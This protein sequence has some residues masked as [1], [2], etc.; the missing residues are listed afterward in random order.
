MRIE[1]GKCSYRS[2]SMRFY[3]TAFLLVFSYIIGNAQSTL[4]PAGHALNF[5]TVNDYVVVDNLKSFDFSAN[6]WTIALWV[7]PQPGGDNLQGLVTKRNHSGESGGLYYNDFS[8]L[9]EKNTQ[10]LNFTY[11][12]ITTFKSKTAVFDYE[13]WT[14]IA[15]K[16]SSGKIYFYYD[17]V[18]SDSLTIS[19]SLS[20]RSNI[21][22]YIGSSPITNSA[23]AGSFV[24]SMD[25]VQ[26]WNV[27]LTDAAIE[28]ILH[29]TLS[30]SYVDATIPGAVW[31]NLIA[32]YRFDQGTASGN[33]SAISTIVSEPDLINSVTTYNGTLNGFTRSG[34][35]SNFINSSAPAGVITNQGITY[36]SYNSVAVTGTQTGDWLLGDPIIERGVVYSTNRYFDPFFVSGSSMT[37]V[38]SSTLLSQPEFTV[39]IDDLASGRIYYY[40]SYIRTNSG[41]YAYGNE[42]ILA[43]GLEPTGNALY[44]DGVNDSLGIFLEKVQNLSEWSFSMWIKPESGVSGNNVLL[45]RYFKSGVIYIKTLTLNYDADNNEFDFEYNDGSLQSSTIAANITEGLW[46]HIAFVFDGTDVK[47][48]LNGTLEGTVVSSVAPQSYALERLIVGGE[49]NNTSGLIQNVFEGE[50]DELTFWN[51]DITSDLDNVRFCEPNKERL[52]TA[53]FGVGY[54][55]LYLYLNF[56]QGIA[57]GNNSG[58]GAAPKI[59]RIIDWGPNNFNAFIANFDLGNSSDTVSNFTESGLYNLLTL[60]QILDISLTS[61]VLTGYTSGPWFE[62]GMVTRGVVVS[63]IE[64]FDPRNSDPAD[65]LMFYSSTILTKDTFDVQVTGLDLNTRYF[66]RVFAVTNEGVLTFANQEEL[67]TSI[68][69][70]GYALDFDGANDRVQTPVTRGSLGANYTLSAWFKYEGSPTGG[71]SPIFGAFD[72]TG[73]SDFSLSKNTGNTNFTYRDGTFRTDFGLGTNAWD[74]NWHHVAVVFKTSIAYLYLDGILVAHNQFNGGAGVGELIQVGW[75]QRYNIAFNGKIDEVQIWN[76]ALSASQIKDISARTIDNDYITNTLGLSSASLLAYYRFDAGI[77]EGDNTSISVLQD[78]SST[79]STA[80]LSGFALTGTNSNFVHSEAGMGVQTLELSAPVVGSSTT[81]KG[82]IT[83]IWTLGRPTVGGFCYSTQKS[84]NYQAQPKVAATVNGDTLSATINSLAL[85]ETYFYRAWIKDGNDTVWGGERSFVVVTDVPGNALDLDG[86]NDVVIVPGNGIDI[87]NKSFTLETWAKKSVDSE[88]GYFFGQG[89]TI[90]SQGLH[91]GYRSSTTLTIAFYGNDANFI[92]NPDDLWHHYA[93]VYDAATKTRRFYMDGNLLY[94][95]TN[96]AASHYIGSGDFYVGGGFMQT[97][98]DILNEFGG[99]MDETRIWQGA[100]DKQDIRKLMSRTIDQAW[101]DA[102]LSGA[103][104]NDLLAY[105]RF[106]QGTAGVDNNTE[107]VIFDYSGKGNNGAWLYANY[108]GNTSNFVQSKAGMGAVI[109]GVVPEKTSV[110]VSAETTGIW[111]SGATP[112]EVGFYYHTIPVFTASSASK[113]VASLSGSTFNSNITG[114]DSTETYYIRAYLRFGTDTVWS[115]QRVFVTASNPPGNNLKFDGTNDYVDV[116]FDNSLNLTENFTVEAWVSG[117]TETWSNWATIVFK[118]NSYW[119]RTQQGSR[120]MYFYVYAGGGWRT[121]QYI[122]PTG[123]DI[124]KWHHYAGVLEGDTLRILVD[125]IV[126]AET[127]MTQAFDNT[128][129]SSLEIGPRGNGNN[130]LNIDE[131]RIWD[132]NLSTEDL[133]EIKNRTLT[134]TWVNGTMASANWPNLKAY[135]RFDQGIAGGNNP[136]E[137][138]LY[139]FSDYENHGSLYNFAL[140]G[141]NSN[142]VASDAYL[143]VKTHEVVAIG[144]DDATIRGSLTTTW[145][146]DID[147]VGLVYSATQGFDPALA[148]GVDIF[149][150]IAQ[151]EEI[152]GEEFTI[153]IA[154][155]V[156]GKKYFF[157]AFARKNGRTVYGE[158]KF[159]ATAINPPGNA[160]DL[161]GT[162]DYVSVYSTPSLSPSNEIT[163]EFWS[164]HDGGP[165]WSSYYSMLSKN[166]SYWIL[167]IGGSRNLYFRVHDSNSTYRQIVFYI[168]MGIDIE[169][170]HHYAFTYDGMVMKMYVDG[171]LLQSQNFGTALGIHQNDFELRIGRSPYGSTNSIYYYNGRFDEVRIWHKALSA[172]QIDYLKNRTINQDLVNAMV[173]LNWV[174]L[175]VNFRFDQGLAGAEN[176]GEHYVYDFSGNGNLGILN[177][178]SLVGNN[179]NWVRSDAALG[180]TTLTNFDFAAGQGTFRGV[181]TDLWKGTFLERGIAYSSTLNFSPADGDPFTK[182]A[183]V[184]PLANDTFESTVSGLSATQMIFYR[185]YATTDNALFAYGESQAFIPGINP[186]GNALDFDGINDYFEIGHS[187]SISPEEELTVEFWLRNDG[188]PNWSTYGFMEK[189]NEYMIY[190]YQNSDNLL[191]RVYTSDNSFRQVVYNP[192]ASFNINQYHHYAFTYDGYQVRIYVDGLLKANA[193][194]GSFMPIRDNQTQ[195]LRVGRN[196]GYYFNGEMDELRIW[197]KALTESQLFAMKNRTIDRQY[198][199]SLGGGL[200]YDDLGVYMRFDQGIANGNNVGI[201]ILYDYTGNKNFG[202]FFNFAKTGTTSNF[203][204]SQAGLG[205]ATFVPTGV[206]FDQATLNGSLTGIFYDNVIEKGFVIAEQPFNPYNPGPIVADTVKVAGTTPGDYSA[207]VDNLGYLTDY[208]YNAYYKTDNGNYIYANQVNFSTTLNPPGF[209]LHFDRT[210]DY[211]SLFDLETTSKDTITVDFWMYWE[212]FLNNIAYNMN[213]MGFNNYGLRLTGGFFGFFTNS[214][215]LYGMNN[216]AD[217]ANRWVHVAAVF[218]RNNVGANKLFING[219]EQQ[220]EQKFTFPTERDFS[221]DF[222]IGSLNN[223]N[224]DFFKGAID[225]F[226]FWNKGLNAT[227][228]NQIMDRTLDVPTVNAISGLTYDNLLVYYRFDQGTPGGNNAGLTEIRDLSSYAHNATLFNFNLT[229]NT[230]NI[231]VSD[232]NIGVKTVPTVT[233]E[234]LD[235]AKLYGEITG[236]WNTNFTDSGFVYSTIEHFNPVSQG[237]FAPANINEGGGQFA[238]IISGLTNSTEYFFRSYVVTQWDTPTGTVTDTVYGMEKVFLS[239]GVY[240]TNKYSD[241]QDDQIEL[242]YRLIGAPLS[243]ALTTGIKYNTTKGFDPVSSGTSVVGVSYSGD[244]LSSFITGLAEGETYYYRPYVTNGTTTLYG[245]E[246]FFVTGWNAAGNSLKFNTGNDYLIT[247]PANEILTSHTFTVTTWVKFSSTN[248]SCIFKAPRFNSNDY[249]FSI[250]ANRNAMNQTQAGKITVLY[251]QES[252]GGEW[253]QS[254]RTDLNDGNWHYVAVVMN[255]EGCKLYIDGELEGESPFRL[256]TGGFGYGDTYIGAYLPNNTSYNGEIEEFRIWNKSLDILQ[257]DKLAHR[258]IDEEFVNSQMENLSWEDLKLYYRFDQGIAGGNN[259]TETDVFDYSQYGRHGVISGLD[260]TGVNANWLESTAP[261]GVVTLDAQEIYTLGEATLQ[262]YTTDMWYTAPVDTG[263]VYSTTNNF[264]SA[265]GTVIEANVHPNDSLFIRTLMGLNPVQTYYFRAYATAANGRTTY[266]KQMTFIP[267][268]VSTIDSVGEYDGAN[269]ELFGVVTGDFT[270]IAGDT[271]VWYAPVPNFNPN[272]YPSNYVLYSGSVTDTFMVNATGLD[273][274]RTYYYR[275]FVDVTS[276]SYSG[277]RVFGEERSFRTL[278]NPPG[279]ALDFDGVNDWLTVYSVGNAIGSNPSLG[280]TFETWVQSGVN[281]GSRTIF[282]MTDTLGDNLRILLRTIDYNSRRT[283][284]LWINN[285]NYYSN[286]SIED[287]IWHHVALTVDPGSNRTR[288]YLDGEMVMDLTVVNA[289]SSTD[290]IGLSAQITNLRNVGSFFRGR[291][292]EVR[293]WNKPLTPAQL[294]QMRYRTIDSQFVDNSVASLNWNNLIGYF[295][296]DEGISGLAND[297]FYLAKDLSDARQDAFLNRFTLNGNTSNWVFSGAPLGVTTDNAEAYEDDGGDFYGVITGVWYSPPLDSGIVISDVSGFDPLSAAMI[298]SNVTATTDTFKVELRDILV[299]GQYY[300]YRSYVQVNDSIYTY[301]LERSFYA[302]GILTLDTVANIT[303]VEATCFGEI[304]ANFPLAIDTGI[305]FYLNAGSNPDTVSSGQFRSTTLNNVDVYWSR[306]TGL[307]PGTRYYYRAYIQLDGGARIYGDEYS[308][309]TVSTPPGRAMNLDQLTDFIQVNNNDDLNLADAMTYELWA[310]SSTELWSAGSGNDVML[311]KG[312]GYL[313]RGASNTKRIE[314]YFFFEGLGWRNINFNPADYFRIDEWHH[315]AVSFDGTTMAFYV[316]GYLIGSSTA[317]NGYKIRVNSNNLHIG[318]D[319][320][321]ANESQ[322]NLRGQVDE[323]RIWNKGL[324]QEQIKKMMFRTID[325]N[326]LAAYVPDLNWSNLML[327]FPMDDGVAGANNNSLTIM[328]DESG[329]NNHGYY[330]NV[331]LTGFNSNFVQSGAN[332][333]VVTDSIIYNPDNTT[334]ILNGRLTGKW[335]AYPSQV[336][337]QYSTVRDFS[338]APVRV[339]GTVNP[340]DST[341]SATVAGLNPGETYY[342]RAITESGSS[343]SYG[344]A[345]PLLTMIGNPNGSISNGNALALDGVDDYVYVQNPLFR[346]DSRSFTLETWARKRFNNSLGYL[347]GMGNTNATNVGLHVG[348]RNFNTLT[349]DFWGNGVN[350]NVIPDT[351]WHHYAFVYDAVTKTRNFYYDGRLIRSFTNAALSHFV[352]TGDFYVGARNT[353]ANRFGGEMD[354]VRVWE[355]ALTETQINTIRTRT[356]DSLYIS[357]SVPGLNWD[358]LKLYYRFDQGIPNGNNYGEHYVFDYSNPRNVG[359]LTNSLLSGTESN[360]IRR[361]A[362]MG[363]V[364]TELS[365]IGTTYAHIEGQVTGTWNDSIVLRGVVYSPLSEFDPENIANPADTVHSWSLTDLSVPTFKVDLTGLSVG[366]QYSYAT[367]VV[368]E[369]GDT[370]YS[371]L[372]SFNTVMDPSGHALSLDGSNDYLLI[373]DTL[374]LNSRSFS[375]EIWARKRATNS[376][377]YFLWQGVNANNNG[378]YIGYR[379]ATTLTIAF[380]NNDVNVTVTPDTLWHAYTFVYDATTKTRKIFMDGVKIYEFTNI[381]RE[382]YLGTGP[383][384][385]GRIYW[386][387]YFNGDIDEARIWQVALTDAQVAELAFRTIDEE[388]IT[389]EVAG[390]NWSDLYVNYRFDQGVPAGNNTSVAYVTDM[391]GNHHTGVL[392]NMTLSGATSNWIK[393]GAGM[394]VVTVRPANPVLAAT[395]TLYSRVT[396]K[397]Y[398]EVIDSGVVY[399]NIQNFIPG[400][401]SLGYVSSNLASV[402]DT[403]RTQLSGL[404]HSTTYYYRPYVVSSVND[405]VYGLQF[406]FTTAGISTLDSSTNVSGTYMT[407]FGRINRPFAATTDTGIVYSLTRDFD[408]ATGTFVSGSK[409]PGNSNTFG[410]NLTGLAPSTVYFFRAYAT[411]GVSTMYGEQRMARTLS[412]PAGNALSFDGINDWVQLPSNLMLSSGLSGSNEITIEFYFKGTDFQ[413]VIRVQEGTDNYIV[414]GFNNPPLAVFSNNSGV[415][416][417]LSLSNNANIEDNNWHHV[418]ITWKRN[419]PSGFRAYIDGI[420][421]DDNN[422]TNLALPNFT[423]N[424]TISIG[425]RNGDVAFPFMNGSIDEIRFWNKALTEEQILRVFERTLDPDFVDNHV[426]G[427]SW[428][429]LVAYYRSDMGLGG[430]DNTAVYQFDDLSGNNYHGTPINFALN[431]ATSNF[432]ESDAFSG[433]ITTPDYY[434]IPSSSEADVYAYITGVWYDAIADSGAVFSLHQGFDPDTVPSA[435]YV[436][437]FTTSADTFITRLPNLVSGYDYYYRAYLITTTGDTAFGKESRLIA[438]GI[439]TMTQ[440]DRLGASLLAYGRMTGEFPSAS[441]TGM[442]YSTVDGFDPSDYKSNFVSVAHSARDTFHAQIN[443]LLVNTDYYYRA[444]VINGADTLYGSQRFYH[445]ADNPAGNGL[446]YDGIND[447]VEVLTPVAEALDLTKEMTIEAWIKPDDVD[448]LLTFIGFTSSNGSFNRLILSVSTGKSITAIINNTN[449]PFIGGGVNVVDGEWHHVAFVSKQT[450]ALTTVYIDGIPVGTANMWAGFNPTDILGIGCEFNYTTGRVPVSHYQGV[451]DEIR[452]WDKALTVELLDKFRY[453]TVSEEYLDTIPGITG[454][455][456]IAYYRFDQ[457]VA[458]GNNAGET[459]LFDFSGNAHHGELFNFGLSGSSTNWVESGALTGVVTLTDYEPSLTSALVK[460]LK[461]GMWF[462]GH[463]DIGV[464]YSTIDGFDPSTGTMVQDDDLLLDGDTIKST[465]TGLTAGGVY[466]YRAYVEKNGMV[467]YGQQATLQTSGVYTL[468]QFENVSGES[469]TLFGSIVGNIDAE[470][471]GFRF[472]VNS[473]LSGSIAVIVPSVPGDTFNVTINGLTPGQTYYFNAFVFT[474]GP[475]LV[476]GETLKFS[477]LSNPAGNALDFDA[478]DSYVRFDD[479]S[480]P[481]AV[482]TV[483]DGF[484]VETWFNTTQLLTAQALFAFHNSTGSINRFLIDITNDDRLAIFINNVQYIIGNDVTDEKW[485]HLAVV[486]EKSPAQTRVYLDGNLV[487]TRNEWAGILTND[488]FVIGGELDNSIIDEVLGGKLDEFRV[489][490]APLTADQIK[491]VSIASLNADYVNNISGLSW[492]DLVAYFNFDFS[493]ESNDN[494]VWLP[495]LLDV[496]GNENHGLLTNFTLNG[497]DGNFVLS[498]LNIG[499][500]PIGV[501]SVDG[502]SADVESEVIGAWYDHTNISRGVVF[503]QIPRFDANNP[504]Q[505]EGSNVSA[506]GY[507]IF[508]TTL[509]SLMDGTKYY[510]RPYAEYNGQRVYGDIDSVETSNTSLYYVDKDAVGANNGTSWADAFTSLAQALRVAGS[511][512]SVFVAEG[513]YYPEFDIN[514]NTNPADERTKS[515]FIRPGV[516]LFGGFAGNELTVETRSGAAGATILSGDI[517]VLGNNSDNSYHVLT[518]NGFSNDTMHING[519]TIQDGNADGALM[520]AFGGGIYAPGY[521]MIIESSTLRNNNAV[522]GGAVYFDASNFGWMKVENSTFHNNTATQDGGALYLFGLPEQMRFDGI[523]DH[524]LA[525]NSVNTRRYYTLFARIRTTDI[526]T[527]ANKVNSPAII[528]AES[529]DVILFVDNGYLGYYDTFGSVTTVVTSAFIADGLEHEVAAV[530][531]NG[532]VRIFVDGVQVGTDIAT[533]TTALN[534]ANLLFGTYNTHFAGNIFEIKIFSRNLSASEMANIGSV[535]TNIAAHYINTGNTGGAGGTWADQSVNSYHGVVFGTPDV[536]GSSDTTVIVVNSTF[537][538]NSYGDEGIIYVDGSRTSISNTILWN[539]GNELAGDVGT[540][541]HSVM[542]GGTGNSATDLAQNIWPYDPMLDPKGLQ[543]NG[544]L[545]LTIRPLYGP[546]V[547][548]GKVYGAPL[549][550]AT[551]AARTAVPDIGAVEYGSKLTGNS[552]N[553]NPGGVYMT[554]TGFTSFNGRTLEF[555]IKPVA[556]MQGG[557]IRLS[558]THTITINASNQ[559]VANGFTGSTIYID[560]V[561]GTTLTADVWQHVT[562]VASSDF[563]VSN[564]QIGNVNATEVGGNID[565]LRIWNTGLTTTQIHAVRFIELTNDGTNLVNP[566]TRSVVS[567]GALNWSNLKLNY[568]FYDNRF[569]EI[570]SGIS[571]T[572]TNGA[573]VE[574]VIPFDHWMPLALTNDWDNAANWYFGLTPD[575]INTGYAVLNAGSVQPRI[576]IGGNAASTKTVYGLLI[577]QGSSFVVEQGKLEITGKI[578]KRPGEVRVKVPGGRVIRIYNTL[579]IWN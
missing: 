570:A 324:T 68:D 205:V 4:Q 19:G 462:N 310:K 224:G 469:I 132:T 101:T 493:D 75:D 388:Y 496:S 542:R 481:T 296:F 441:D 151:T 179:S 516:C 247:A 565:E 416:G 576:N 533:G 331:E 220:L 431:G 291:M 214:V 459:Q 343:T 119:L 189:G 419:T 553:L 2:S 260:L 467:K 384:E 328:R 204:R 507:G 520:N 67:L 312:E 141:N 57:Y 287:N 11:K 319:S 392:N 494:T 262:G 305:V 373:Q 174:D 246:Q 184:T 23:T 302:G 259:L 28:D 477:T 100:L 271:G 330:R 367:M 468:N 417:A 265:T 165:L 38:S 508:Q 261:I 30:E 58:T 344:M 353:G 452:I 77:P 170:W 562:V 518:V 540:I 120:N 202:T 563:T 506:N 243:G 252:G 250:F 244:T 188:S 448:K 480:I 555:W 463:D 472:S 422:A 209:A 432:I 420:L 269:A 113:V 434:T 145:Y 27:A 76:I 66:Y 349:I 138:F 326:Y 483:S 245:N 559:V 26:F 285:T 551:G 357:S 160:L 397:W 237:F 440:T 227:Q 103:T 122:A 169:D 284:S 538:G 181:S 485:H 490:S 476:E 65:T 173:G 318:Q 385:I 333:G 49:F 46:N 36:T 256:Y 71:Y 371:S 51:K 32:Y 182:V 510:F 464:V 254:V 465:I 223:F 573:N 482:A 109:T 381:A 219:E 107:R 354:E 88:N 159:F 124:R 93:F 501:V 74:G 339:Y 548:G 257:L 73:T 108:S 531:E 528:S 435:R 449:Y 35:S 166:N 335:Y 517:G 130:S 411:D 327:Y 210:S 453:R 199:N 427:L 95:F 226:R 374:A 193:V 470:E 361:S 99:Q 314:A 207:E 143:G 297:A 283:L 369:N 360:W 185:A 85:G 393:S 281:T 451:L 217:L 461:T 502:I 47:Y 229:G 390:L 336:G 298:S 512:D 567:A 368:A 341:F 164:R 234:E 221:Q 80:T 294:A 532:A 425:S 167:P 523:N 526:R 348:Y 97:N 301:G 478:T 278:S 14:H 98:A 34:N 5:G 539:Q 395:A 211:L 8:I 10:L 79:G 556:P 213:V 39:Q 127:A 524:V 503:S 574:A 40:K 498:D 554:A 458:G 253:V 575:N 158:E 399:S 475:A 242:Y 121:V 409:L 41:R 137:N 370:A 530:R 81:V 423:S 313:F 168:P 264:V 421:V 499:V 492:N 239:A 42:R 382:H 577:N 402:A 541:T 317:F 394:G 195:S 192:P 366:A 25:E 13:R 20:F 150:E 352:G 61:A 206:S 572:T 133:R 505:V 289:M 444:Y 54:S 33:N 288:V 225:E 338:V 235:E 87:A 16:K 86:A 550:D 486:S 31:S 438:G 147:T 456:L 429:N 172:D 342:Y 315:Y 29:R 414:I 248:N 52:D 208:Y 105:Y 471:Y 426:A 268:G 408:P 90:N 70:P 442:V 69:P 125:G 274:G 514:G 377:G 117:V 175:G 92:V 286:V 387:N 6:N 306:L 504:A 329:R 196:G 197:R 293:F 515:F 276:G 460:G 273:A 529:G 437:A 203:V 240:P 236:I 62:N 83:D 340:V 325:A 183:S 102:N 403:F 355:K 44:F 15:V 350:V 177:N 263:F 322:E 534:S 112:N 140:S 161:D 162:N 412:N 405:T 389:N 180:V 148:N 233:D 91:V 362:P 191:F 406:D 337:F 522:N 178:F 544:G 558:A 334:Y 379:N 436:T 479:A 378:L 443:N 149:E 424:A 527:E 279:N 564:I 267:G 230:G 561:A 3:V 22:V 309:I 454:E 545:V 255:T 455:N 64:N 104:W 163:I 359:Y 372:G 17:G 270:G 484:T 200:T 157:R 275:A 53:G 447:R 228:I 111:Y 525:A 519:V 511:S 500:K 251:Q 299:P 154:G 568:R 136:N 391:S 513:I 375:F 433:I 332:T 546:A 571:G 398:S 144:F 356:I 89:T 187:G 474:S 415:S 43:T 400:V 258:V 134:K 232:A 364:S 114:L 316:D 386:G 320:R 82:V 497:N 218:V 457:G 489:W 547:D 272:N 241:L 535:T 142:W 311:S 9:Y 50:I 566:V 7:K 212:P 116:P 380:W 407:L 413:Q 171:K 72:P 549:V 401:T 1:T 430:E 135:Y 557:Y 418:A 60:E 304:T 84:F 21:P 509:T 473:N 24:G 215:D 106:D 126:Y 445:T 146:D 282:C 466:Y 118:P 346:L 495:Y 12:S 376:A 266:G 536:I 48:Y 155:L 59:D 96:P 277:S 198:V 439:E 222:R 428:S 78:F 363:V 290:I 249:V 450:P 345:R 308:F 295:R 238:R 491:E 537:A 365:D 552:L 176:P 156:S 115:R 347:F 63:K 110:A 45:N 560:G 131:V 129:Q 579:K 56:N 190:P 128:N 303:S 280:Y 321:N 37:Y 123:F 216:A 404:E 488:Q 569:D 307:E 231:I 323:V 201:P 383:T 18:L 153:D 446:D 194:Y 396:G 186:P 55:D 521:H 487:F 152:N 351:L 139:D 300:Y 410:A 358:D 292:D 578:L 94:S 543:D